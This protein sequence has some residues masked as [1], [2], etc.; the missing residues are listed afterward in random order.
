MATWTV[1]IEASFSDSID[2][3]ADSE[4]EALEIAVDE[5]E[6][7]YTVVASYGLSWDNVEAVSAECEDEDGEE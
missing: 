1:Q 7:N 3:E 5:F 6:A 4:D 2:V